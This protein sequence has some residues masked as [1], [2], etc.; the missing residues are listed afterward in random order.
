VAF[1]RGRL[2][3]HLEAR[4]RAFHDVLPALERAKSALT[5]AVPG[6][7]LPGRPLAETLLEFEEGLREVRAGM[8]AWRTPEVQ[9]VWTR[10]SEGLDEAIDR[11]ER[12]RLAAPAPE[13]FEGLIGLLAD[14]FVPLESFGDAAERFRELKRRGPSQSPMP[15]RP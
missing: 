8:Q 7:R 9:E 2:P 10:A 3:D 5:T 15:R 1:L 12:A 11:T 13:G 4:R 6:T 14:L